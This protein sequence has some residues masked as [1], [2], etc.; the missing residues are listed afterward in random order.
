LCIGGLFQ[1]KVEGKRAKG[2]QKVA[3]EENPGAAARR[4]F[5]GDVDPESSNPRVNAIFWLLGAF[6][7]NG[8]PLYLKLES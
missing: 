4:Q 5:C 2:S 7:D 6:L 3:E 8:F 1:K